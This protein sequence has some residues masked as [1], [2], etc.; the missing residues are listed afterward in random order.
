MKF[1][2]KGGFFGENGWRQ[3]SLWT[4]LF[5]LL[6]FDCVRAIVKNKNQKKFEL[7]HEMEKDKYPDFY[8]EKGKFLK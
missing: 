5:D 7:T 3:V 6:L 1:Y 2:G 4:Y 8:N